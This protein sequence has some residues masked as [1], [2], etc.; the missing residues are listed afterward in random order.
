MVEIY[1]ENT[2]LDLFN[3]ESINTI[4]S[5]QN[6]KDIA[7]IFTTYT[8][9][10]TI[11]ASKKNNQFFKHFYNYDIVNGFDARVKVECKIV[12]NGFVRYNGYFQ[13][14]GVALKENE[15][16]H[17]KIY[18][19]GATAKLKEILKDFRL[20]DLDYLKQYDHEYSV[21]NI[22]T[23]LESELFSG[24]LKYPFVSAE[25]RLAYAS[26][27][28]KKI[29]TEGE[30]S[31]DTAVLSAE[32]KPAI[33]V[34]EVIKAIDEKF[35]EIN[36]DYS[37]FGRD[38]FKDLYLWLHRGKDGAKVSFAKEEF[39]RSNLVGTGDLLTYPVDGIFRII[40]D[41][42]NINP[43][44]PA[45]LNPIQTYD[46]IDLL[47]TAEVDGDFT[48][49]I[50]DLLSNQ[51]LASGGGVSGTPETIGLTLALQGSYQPV[52]IIQTE[53]E[54]ATLLT[55][56]L[57]ITCE[58]VYRDSNGIQT[59]TR[60]SSWTL[61]LPTVRNFIIQD[62]VPNLNIIDFLTSLFKMF[63]LTAYVKDDVIMIQTLDNYYLDGKE[64]DISKHV[65]I[66]KTEVSR[67]DT[68]N[69]I[70]FKFAE[71]KTF[72][73]KEYSD[74]TGRIY[75]N[76]EYDI[77]ED[78]A[79]VNKLASQ[80]KYEVKVGFEKMLYTD[81][82]DANGDGQGVRYGASVNENNE[83]TS[84]KPLLLFVKNITKTLTFKSRQGGNPTINQVNEPSNERLLSASVAETINF[85]SDI[86]GGSNI[87]NTRSLYSLY[88]ENFIKANFSPRS[89]M[90]ALSARLS[91]DFL[92]NYQLN[93]KLIIQ[94]RKYRINEIKIDWNKRQAKLQLLNDIIKIKKLEV[95][96]KSFDFDNNSNT[97]VIS[98]DSNVI[99]SVDN[100]PSWILI[101]G[102]SGVN[103]GSFTINVQPNNTTESREFDLIV[104]GEGVTKV[105]PITQQG[106]FLEVQPTIATLDSG[107][108]SQTF[109]VSS[110]IN[111]NV[112][113]LPSWLSINNAS[114]SNNGSFQ[115][116]SQVNTNANSRSDIIQLSGGG[117]T[118]NIDITQQGQVL[119]INPQTK[120]VSASSNVYDIL[121]T[122]NLNWN[123]V[124]ADSWATLSASSGTGNGVIT[125]TV[126][127]NTGNRRNTTITFTGGTLT[128]VHTLEQEAFGI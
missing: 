77:T 72:Y 116:T 58:D 121:V 45:P 118:L 11:P 128:E 60:T 66:S 108:D 43:T 105:I 120:D 29:N 74:Q 126:D 1:A 40:E 3:D 12:F 22:I 13:L 51:V 20:E 82:L 111:W 61:S 24:V 88:Y 49:Q 84:I 38:L 7:K 42:E 87:Q 76:L 73:A 78:L 4:D 114:G 59:I 110:N 16:S 48:Y 37:F 100:V 104:S 97:R 56:S 32:F 71:Q 65:D 119:E 91:N 33:Q 10:F 2:R 123:V 5:I 17:Y 28:V 85:G 30:I 63:N 81:L 52:L 96:P 9:Q 34:F 15:P 122:S 70:N 102:G 36:F 21:A 18:F 112:T 46:E 79:D 64:W 23:G 109:N 75:G 47:Y 83:S 127:P 8:Q 68:F 124:S 50:I 39:N 55:G 90:L 89:R 41:R 92:L 35:D 86:V 113:G 19:V 95:N 62:Q 6:V 44:I 94:G 98:V 25:S 125:V 54:N 107:V 67:I 99:W 53:D 115:I 80:R 117:I 93:D 106:I 27:T 69:Q 101:T 14:N 103:N 26:G 31:Q 57:D